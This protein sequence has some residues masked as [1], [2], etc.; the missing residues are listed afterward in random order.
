MAN[1]FTLA[2]RVFLTFITDSSV[3]KTNNVFINQTMA[4]ETKAHV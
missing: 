4:L 1:I 2:W 3:Y